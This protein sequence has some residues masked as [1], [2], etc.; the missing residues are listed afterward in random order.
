LSPRAS[1]WRE[2]ALVLPCSNSHMI[3]FDL[4]ESPHFFQVNPKLLCVPFYILVV[5][6]QPCLVL[7]FRYCF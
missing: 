3:C 1:I 5:K 6:S 2:H 4:L 7:K